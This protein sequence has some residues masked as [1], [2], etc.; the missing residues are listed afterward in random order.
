M[1]EAVTAILPVWG[2]PAPLA[3]A[4]AS[5]AAQTRAVARAI[6]VDDASE[7]R[8]HAPLEAV[9]D[10]ARSTGL[11]VQLI[12]RTANGGPGAARNDGWAAADTPL[13]AFLDA[14][15]AWHPDK[16]ARQADLMARTGAV[17]SAHAYAPDR[18]M[19]A[20]IPGARRLGFRAFV[21]RNRISTPCAMLRRDAGARFPERRRSEDYHLWLR[22]AHRAPVPVLA[23]ELARGFKPAWGAAGLSGDVAAMTAAQKETYRAIGREG[24]VPRAAVPALLAWSHLRHLRRR[25]L[26][27]RAAAASSSS[28]AQSGA[29]SSSSSGARS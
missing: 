18:A 17:L 28:G 2:D 23:A 20:D 9:V 4:L 11:D 3:R 29:Q 24:L 22:L 10:E 27:P 14:D 8:W 1:A 19:D 16:I 6:V 15:D 13:I 21:L 7:T 12:R 26:A 5:V 25:A